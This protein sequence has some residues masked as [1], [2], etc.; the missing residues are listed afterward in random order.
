MK[1]N[2][3]KLTIASILGKPNYEYNVGDVELCYIDNDF[4]EAPGESFF[5]Y[6]AYRELDRMTV[7]GWLVYNSS[8]ASND[9]RIP[10]LGSSRYESRCL[11]VL[12][13]QLNEEYCVAKIVNQKIATDAD[14]LDRKVYVRLS[15]SGDMIGIRATP[16]DGEFQGRVVVADGY[17]ESTDNNGK[18]FVTAYYDGKSKVFEFSEIP[19]GF[20]LEGK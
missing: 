18:L 20:S 6:A 1:W 4:K 16:Y 2:D 10:I 17:V 11:R 3:A 15:D 12:L 5:A 8:P 13:L 19:P 7:D 9:W 14:N